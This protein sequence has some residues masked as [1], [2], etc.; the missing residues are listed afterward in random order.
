[1]RRAA[2]AMVGLL[3][4]CGGDQEPIHHDTAAIVGG[5]VTTGDPAVMLL[6]AYP[7]DHLTLE[8]CTASLVG[9]DLLLTA[10]HCVDPLTHPDH[11][12]GLFTGHD[13]S[14]YPTVNTL[15]PQLREVASA[16][17]HPGYQR[18]APFE[19]DIALVTLAEPLAVAPLFVRRTPLDE[20]VIGAP[21]RIVGYGA[22]TYGEIDPRRRS[23]TTE[24]VAL[25]ASDTVEIG[26]LEHRACVGDSGGPALIAAAGVEMIF[27]VDSYSDIQGCL[28]P[29]HYRR[30]DVYA[31]F[32]EG[33]VPPAPEET[34]G[35]GAGGS[36]EAGGAGGCADCEPAPA[37]EDEGG[38]SWSGRE[39]GS[40]GAWL[41]TLLL[42][43]LGLR[44]R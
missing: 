26:D 11:S 10:A 5:E 27:G 13:A 15:V 23:A 16:E 37:S 7:P 20:S 33:R 34:G 38:C 30:T 6:V 8:L 19:A 17:L 28:E 24:V 12:Y 44:R 40:G 22:A 2:L 39:P 9:P 42:L 4:A 25:G 18:E 29:A 41:A 3:A 31:D 14:A 35:G 43:G 21:V 36:G 32:L 1:M